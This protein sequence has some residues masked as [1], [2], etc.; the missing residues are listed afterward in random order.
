MNR[1]SRHQL[2][3][4]SKTTKIAG[5]STV[6]KHSF[7]FNYVEHTD[8]SAEDVTYSARDLIPYSERTEENQQR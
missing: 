5:R 7:E 3:H 2:Q 1:K 6:R 8:P 4:I